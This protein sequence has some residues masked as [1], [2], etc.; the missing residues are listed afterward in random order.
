MSHTKD[1]F[2]PRAPKFPYYDVPASDA[3]MYDGRPTRG[4]GAK[5]PRKP[6]KLRSNSDQPVSGMPASATRDQPRIRRMAGTRRNTNANRRNGGGGMYDSSV[7]R[8]GMMG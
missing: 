3:G 4:N 7:M 1:G 6:A 5:S 8:E 2:G